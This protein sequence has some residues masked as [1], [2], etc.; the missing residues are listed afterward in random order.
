MY[1]W[2]VRRQIRS[3]FAA[4]SRGDAPALTNHMSPDV[5]HSFPGHGALGG[6]RHSLRDVKAWFDR[7]FEVLPGLQ[8]QIHTLAVDGPPWDTRVGVEWTNSGR[9]LDGSS[10]SNTGAHI[11][12][13]KNGHITAFHA[14][15]ND[16][17]ELTQALRRLSE[18][19]IEHAQAPP[20]LTTDHPT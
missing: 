12:R 9:L 6:E 14:Y 17:D 11:L 5:H 2:F 7:L 18:H 16:T 20:I 8:F 19:G 15:L 13:L 3:A 4:L 10:Y 1:H